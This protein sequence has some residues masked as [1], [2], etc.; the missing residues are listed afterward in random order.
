MDLVNLSTDEKENDGYCYIL[1]MMDHFTKLGWAF[2]LPSKQTIY[3]HQRLLE[4]FFQFGPPEILQS[5]NGGNSLLRS[6][7]KQ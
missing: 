3:V 5:D 2:S 4:V 6:L 7:W 1:T